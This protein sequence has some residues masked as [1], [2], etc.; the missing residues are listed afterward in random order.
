MIFDICHISVGP[1]SPQ[2]GTFSRHF[3]PYH[4]Y[5]VLEFLDCTE[6]PNENYHCYCLFMI[7]KGPAKYHFAYSFR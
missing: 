7:G 6:G 3:V 4:F 5:F 1:P 2:Y